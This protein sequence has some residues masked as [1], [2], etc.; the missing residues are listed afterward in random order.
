M[1]GQHVA[2]REGIGPDAWRGACAAS[3]GAAALLVGMVPHVAFA[4]EA[5]KCK[6]VLESGAKLVQ[7]D[8]FSA[9]GAQGS[10]QG[11]LRSPI[12]K[13]P[14]PAVVILHRY[15]GIEPPDCFAEDQ[16]RFTARGWIS[17]VVDSNSAPSD[18]RS[19]AP[20]TRSGYSVEDQA[21]D[22]L[23]AKNYLMSRSDVEADKIVV[24]GHAFGGAALLRAIS[25][26]RMAPRVKAAPDL[27]GPPFAAAA[28]WSPGCPADLHEVQTPLLIVV[29][30][31]DRENPAYACQRMEVTGPAVE[32]L[33]I[34]VFPNVGHNLDALWLPTYDYAATQQA[35]TEIFRFL[36]RFVSR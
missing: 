5:E 10:V 27:A 8:I 20:D 26:A 35:Y 23:G 16:K 36:D 2:R 7:F 18:L 13:G 9:R 1:A 6:A 34:K 12:G 21:V 32:A 33:R 19:G 22:A 31:E 14:F 17:V 11:V 30:S 3:I 25:A 28:A 29:G 4:T 15:F 24:L